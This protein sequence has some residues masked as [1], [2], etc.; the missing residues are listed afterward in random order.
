MPPREKQTWGK[1]IREKQGNSIT[2][3][4]QLDHMGM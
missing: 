2:K 1:E 3:L 4:E